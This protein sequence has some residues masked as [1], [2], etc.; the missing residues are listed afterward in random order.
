M[1]ETRNG[2][3]SIALILLLIG[4]L[5][6]PMLACNFNYKIG[7][8]RQPAI[9]DV[10]MAKR[11][12]SSQ[13]PVEATKVFDE[14]DTFF[15][16]VKVENL[17][18]GSQVTAKWYYGEQ[19]LDQFTLT[20]ETAG[21]GYLGFNLASQEGRWPAGDY[22]I[23]VSLNGVLARTENFSVR[24]SGEEIKT[25]IA[26]AASPTPAIVLVTPGPAT[27]A[28]TATPIVLSI[29]PSATP[30]VLVQLVVPTPAAT[31]PTVPAIPGPGFMGEP[32]VAAPI[33][34]TG[35]LQAVTPA[36]PSAALPTLPVLRIQP[37]LPADSPIK[38]VTMARRLDESQRPLDPTEAFEQTDTFFCSVEVINL[39]AGSQV[40]ANWYRGAELLDQFTL[41]TDKAGSG[42]LGFN[43]SPKEGVW[44]V[45]D[46]RVEIALNGATVAER[47]FSVKPPATALASRVKSAILTKSVDES[48]RA[49][50]PSLVFAPTDVVH[51]SVN[52]DLGLGSE[53]TAKWYQGGQLLTEYMTT[54]T[55]QEN[56]ADTYVDFYLSPAS[57]LEPG[58]YSV[59]ILLD[60]RLSRA[61]DFTV[62]GPTA[63]LPTQ[64]QPIAAE[65]ALP[66]ATV[67]ASEPQIGPINFSL[68]ALT[69]QQPPLP[70]AVFPAGTK[71]VY[72]T[73]SYSDFRQGDIFEQIWYLNGQESG[74]GS[75]AW[76]DAT[77]GQYQGSLNN[78]RGLLPGSYRLDIKLNGRLLGSG[79]FMVEGSS[80][81]PEPPVKPTPSPSPAAVARPKTPTPQQ[82]ARQFKIVYS[83]TQ[84]DIHSLWTIN[85]DGTNR[86]LLTD[87]ASDPAWSPDGNAIVFYGWDGHPR[88]GSGVY[89]ISIDGTSTRQIWNQGSAE[90]LD[91]S[92]D[93]RYIAMNT[94]TGTPNKRLVIY[95]R[96]T[97]TA[98]DLGPGEQPNFSPDGSSIVARTCVGSHC[99]L[100][101]MGRFGEAKTRLTTSADDAMPSWSPL[102]DR[103]AYASQQGG[104]WD[105]WAINTNGT[106]QV[107]L[108]DDPGIDAMPVWLPDGSG[109][110]F[111][112]T[113]DG[114]WGIWVM[115]P[116][117]SNPRKITDA[118]AAAD[119][120]RDRL[121]VR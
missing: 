38:G 22:R 28:P 45:G 102:G 54:V 110:A 78:E 47:R 31:N 81:S 77:T 106:G 100:F 86:S 74:K 16:S 114:A 68:E 112:S 3:Y 13:K 44:P 80:P 26:A 67:A 87:R 42:N 71:T 97:N 116:D 119:W 99:G 65:A 93:G 41:T 10:T 37:T 117:G 104:N 107:R 120:G 61:V 95:D 30:T 39:P 76:V 121:D 48:Y 57:P 43:L 4:T 12:D 60:G 52:A 53:L 21:S 90:Y 55:A 105:I 113:R 66:T 58:S 5:F 115:N 27:S 29:P 40:T 19:L 84:G 75:F 63:A 46:Y 96:S 35:Q 70:R 15:C 1:P 89:E 103:I 50:A 14:T 23:E 17:R 20:L 18:S 101:L 7:A 32:P 49:N 36:T 88:G 25:P 59:E 118:P 64:P 62:Q 92:P 9:A 109:I 8:Q 24:S 69:S 98:Q 51:C 73:F 72:A 91:W 94:I 6:V 111:R 83:M 108:T 56:M 11:L 2:R 34:P 79:Q 33:S 82:P 85:L